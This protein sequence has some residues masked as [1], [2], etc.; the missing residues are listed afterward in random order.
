MHELMASTLDTVIGEIRRIKADARENGFTERPRWPMIVLRTPKGWTCPKE[1]DRRRTEGYWR[2]HQV[3]MGEMHEN[4]AH[5]RI[6][7]D[8][9]KSYQPTELFDDCG[10][11]RPEL[12]DVPPRGMR[13]MSANPHANGGLL[14]RE[15]RLPNFRDYAVDVTAPGVVTAESTRVMGRFLRD[16][17]KLNMDSRNFRLFSPDES[18]SNRWQIGLGAVGRVRV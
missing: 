8:W 17:M 9:M 1:I 18:N 6:L 3:P 11:L 10:Q 14:L 12:A 2:A 7:E 5:V 15:L 13:R 16:V 4:P